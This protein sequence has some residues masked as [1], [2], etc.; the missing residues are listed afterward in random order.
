LFA[1]VEIFVAVTGFGFMQILSRFVPELF[2]ES[3]YATLNRIVILSLALRSLIVLSVSGVIFFASGSI[4][5]WF[6][7]TGMES[8]IKIYL[9]VMCL[10]TTAEFFIQ[11]FESMLKQW[12]SQLAG[13]LTTLLKALQVALICVFFNQTLSL[14]K[15]IQIEIIAEIC[16]LIV[17]F[18]FGFRVFKQNNELEII[19]DGDQ[20]FRANLGRMVKFGIAGYFQHLAILFY[21]GPANRVVVGRLFD[22]TVIASF[23]FA[24]SLIDYIARYLPGRLLLGMIRP[25]LLARFAVDRDTNNLSKSI[26]LIFK[27]DFFILGAGIIIIGIAGKFISSI[28]SGGK[29][30][31]VGGYLILVLLIVLIFE[32]L[33]SL[34]WISL[35][36]LEKNRILL[37]TNVFLSASILLVFPLSGVFGVFSV[38]IANLTGIVV[39][40][41]A[42]ITY[43]NYFGYGIELKWMDFLKLSVLIFVCVVA[44]KLAVSL[45]VKW[46][47]ASSISIFIYC[48][49]VFYSAV[50]SSPEQAILL[51]LRRSSYRDESL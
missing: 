36:A 49:L 29:Y 47:I 7:L 3:R 27:I 13:T 22:T 46:W 43:L 35:E 15:L 33:I 16:G 40:I 37:I 8:T 11:V 31:E 6:S 50:F 19:N 12:L 25:V 45:D 41:L 48:I 26:N 51:N 44:G 17:L 38:A 5:S 23:G 4:A 30:S 18:V 39:S 21:G 2:V 9:L 10:R 42:V 32:A 24:Q 14:S 20:W 28:L 1:F 34:L